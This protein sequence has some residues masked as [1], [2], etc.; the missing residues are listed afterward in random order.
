MT[1]YQPDWST[2]PEWAKWWAIDAEGWAYWFEVEPKTMS[3]FGYWSKG[4]GQCAVDKRFS[5]SWENTKNQ[6]LVGAKGTEA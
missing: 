1:I 6:R 4:N 2:A 3:F 5:F